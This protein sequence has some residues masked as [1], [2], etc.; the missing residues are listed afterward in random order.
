[1]TDFWLFFVVWTAGGLAFSAVNTRVYELRL[2]GVYWAGT[3]V[4]IIGGVLGAYYHT[5]PRA[6]G[7][8]FVVALGVVLWA[9]RAQGI[10]F[11]TVVKRRRKQ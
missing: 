10:P 8:V 6:V 5:G 4:F 3:V 11:Q 1:M 9:V 7:C 2:I